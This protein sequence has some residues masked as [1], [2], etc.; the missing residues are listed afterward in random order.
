MCVC[1]FFAC[2][3]VFEE[4]DQLLWCPDVLS[5]RKVEDYLRK[6]LSQIAD[7]STGNSTCGGHIRDND[8]VYN[9]RLHRASVSY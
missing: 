7:S 4:E 2:S 9:F 8:Q 3:A 1:V 5:E 6:A